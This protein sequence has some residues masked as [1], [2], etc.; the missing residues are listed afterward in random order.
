MV[1]LALLL[2]VLQ[3]LFASFSEGVFLV[4]ARVSGSAVYK[5]L[6][7]YFVAIIC[8]TIVR[9]LQKEEYVYY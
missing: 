6:Y 2:G 7:D 9:D 8:F 4:G 3:K 1:L 5:I